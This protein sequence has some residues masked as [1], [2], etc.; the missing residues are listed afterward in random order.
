M[1]LRG[2]LDKPA[3]LSEPVNVAVLKNC[4]IGEDLA[5]LDERTARR[6]C[7]LR[8]L[9]GEEKGCAILRFHERNPE[10]SV[11][12]KALDTECRDT[13]ISALIAEPLDMP[14]GNTQNAGQIGESLRKGNGCCWFFGRDDPP[15]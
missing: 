13:A 3:D 6:P 5:A 14:D 9:W 10:E 7:H 12:A 1:H 4:N 2:A 11:A 15:P 8:S